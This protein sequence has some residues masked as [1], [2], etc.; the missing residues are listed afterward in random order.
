MSPWSSAPSSAGSAGPRSA[1]CT[2]TP[3][4]ATR[5]SVPARSAGARVERRHVLEVVA[6]PERVPVLGPHHAVGPHPGREQARRPERRDARLDLAHPADR[7]V[8]R[9]VEGRHRERGRLA[10]DDGRRLDAR[11]RDARRRDPRRRDARRRDP[12]GL[13]RRVGEHHVDMPAVELAGDPRRR[14][15]HR[16]G[17]GAEH[18]DLRPERRIGLRPRS[19]RPRSGRPRGRGRRSA[20]ALVQPPAKPRGEPPR[21]PPAGAKPPHV[22]RLR[23]HPRRHGADPPGAPRPPSAPGDR[24]GAA[25]REARGRDPARLAVVGGAPARAPGAVQ[26]PR[27]RDRYLRAV[28]EDGG[29][30]RGVPE[31]RTQ[32]AHQ[33]GDRPG[34]RGKGDVEGGDREG[35][36]GGARGR[37]AHPGVRR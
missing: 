2:G 12:R 15:E 18:R 31:R 14:R 9:R 1:R 23:P 16:P 11:R 37:D 29:R 26:R 7:V 24:E 33:P 22:P 5:A 21:E 27:A 28:A 13:R 8:E 34:A 19:G 17:A 25:E 6:V 35:V 36:E 4:A 20:P 32:T 3:R 30:G 10:E